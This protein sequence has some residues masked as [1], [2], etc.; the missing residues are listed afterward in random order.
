MLIDKLK[1]IS[2]ETIDKDNTKLGTYFPL[3]TNEKKDIEIF[4]S[5]DLCGLLIGL[6]Y[7]LELKKD[8]KKEMFFNKVKNKFLN[9][10]E[11]SENID[12]INDIYF[13]DDKVPTLAPIMYMSNSKSN[14]DTKTKKAFKI[15]TQIFQTIEVNYE[16]NKKF[17][18]IEKIIYEE[19]KSNIQFTKNSLSSNSYIKFLDDIFSLDFTFL[20]KNEHYF[21]SQ[22]KNLLKF[23]MLTYSLQLTLNVIDTPLETPCSKEI[24]FILNHE[25]AAN[26]ERKK[27]RTKGYK[28]FSKKF[29]RL[30]PSLSLLENISSIIDDKNLKYFHFSEIKETQD[31]LLFLRQII[32]DYRNVKE[33]EPKDSKIESVNDFIDLIFKSANEQFTIEE[34]KKKAVI[35]RFLAAFEEQ[36][37]NSFLS[38]RGP[39]GKVLVLDQDTILLL[40]NL[41][42]GNKEQLHFQDLIEEFNKRGIYFDSRSIDEL[43][44]LYERVGNIDRKSD[45]GDAIYV[46][47]TI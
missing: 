28:E 24:Y 7:N 34:S 29:K 26:T 35:T 6:H 11:D 1:S 41:S 44:S 25:K 31:N 15:F 12:I 46:R 19:F 43:I 42:I 17:N 10:M 13:L 40:T 9:R 32:V 3:T 2:K 38:S 37:A 8:F 21:N 14:I 18:F 22:I 36:I 47:T 23:Y 45:S 5:N 16:N 20:L 33:L 39:S 27:I 30:F 4:S